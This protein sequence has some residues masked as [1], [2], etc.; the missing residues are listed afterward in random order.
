MLCQ[1]ALDM[2]N[3]NIGLICVL[4]GVIAI[5]SD[6]TNA[7]ILSALLIGGGSGLFFWKED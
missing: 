5:F 4:L 7:W 2:K 1:Y 3:K 6:H